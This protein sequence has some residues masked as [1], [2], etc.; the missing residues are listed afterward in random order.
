MKQLKYSLLLI[1]LAGIVAGGVGFFTNPDITINLMSITCGSC[2]IYG[3]YDL[4]KKA[5]SEL[6]E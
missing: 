4:D 5:K 6:K 3:Y 2:L 1:G